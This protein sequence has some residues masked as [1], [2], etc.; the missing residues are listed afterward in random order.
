MEK[1]YSIDGLVE[2]C[3]D[4][5]EFISEMIDVFVEN[6]ALYLKELMR[7]FENKDWE[8]LKKNAHKIKPSILLMRIESLTQNI[9]DL[10]EYS[11]KQT[12]LDRIPSLVAELETILNEVFVQMKKK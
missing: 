12:N 4:D 9:L 11:G 1:L 5:Q 8:E 6:N 2:M 3:G 10:N 7:A